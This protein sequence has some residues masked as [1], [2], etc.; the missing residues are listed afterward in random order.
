MND[1]FPPSEPFQVVL[2]YKGP[3][4]PGSIDLITI[5]IVRKRKRLVFFNEINLASIL[6]FHTRKGRPAKCVIILPAS[7][8]ETSSFPSY[9]EPVPWDL[10]FPFTSTQR[11]QNILS[12]S[13]IARDAMSVT[14]VAP[15]D[16]WNYELLEENGELKVKTLVAS[17]KEM[18]AEITEC[19]ST[20]YY[21]Y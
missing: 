8:A 9:M 10:V 12:S 4:T 1:L 21:L 19:A 16:R 2:Q 14:D 3:V 13:S 20:S 15:A 6:H 18:C 11:R 17:V 5:Y 7:L